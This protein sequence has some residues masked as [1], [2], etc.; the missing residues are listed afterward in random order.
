MDKCQHFFPKVIYQFT[1]PLAGYESFFALLFANGWYHQIYF[2]IFYFFATLMVYND[3]HLV[4]TLI[5][6]LTGKVEC[7]F[8]Y[9]LALWISLSPGGWFK[10]FACLSVVLPAFLSSICRNSLYMP[11]INPLSVIYIADIFAYF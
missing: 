11:N 8:T 6:P 7:H 5:F 3:I 4:L 10:T 1:L 9:L 2:F